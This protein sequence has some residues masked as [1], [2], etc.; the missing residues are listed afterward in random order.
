MTGQF[1]SSGDTPLVEQMR[2][3]HAILYEDG[4][5]ALYRIGNIANPVTATASPKMAIPKGQPNPA[6]PVQIENLL[7]FNRAHV[8]LSNRTFRSS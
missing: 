1:F 6:G 8:L 3:A 2:Y 5:Y 7:Y 4:A